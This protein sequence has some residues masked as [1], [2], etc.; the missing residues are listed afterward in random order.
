MNGRRVERS[1]SRLEMDERSVERNEWRVETNEWRVERNG[2]KQIPILINHK[3][4]TEVI[5][6]S[7]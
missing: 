4:N 2:R 6:F 5:M 1:E 3:V 7:K